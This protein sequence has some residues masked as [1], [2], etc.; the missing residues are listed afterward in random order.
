MLI[1]SFYTSNSICWLTPIMIMIMMKP[2]DALSPSLFIFLSLSLLLYHILSFSFF[3]SKRK[4]ANQN[5]LYYWHVKVKQ[6][7]L[8]LTFY[9]PRVHRHNTTQHIQTWLAKHMT[10]KRSQAVAAMALAYAR[11]NYKCIVHIMCLSAKRRN[12]LPM[13]TIEVHT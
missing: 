5:K 4:I 2:Y 1:T 6:H 8:V 13:Q 3:G 11:T 12:S 9:K 7:P 10:R